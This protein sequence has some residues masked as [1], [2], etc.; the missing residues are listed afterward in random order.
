M[1]R[2]LT[3]GGRLVLADGTADR[4]AA[5]IADRLLRRFDRGHVRLYRSA[6]LIELL[7]TA[8]FD[9]IVVHSLWNGGYAIVT[10]RR[11]A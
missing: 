1:A 6:E 7:C 3:A 4:L 11:A 5:R 2:V 10:A 9:E 8:G